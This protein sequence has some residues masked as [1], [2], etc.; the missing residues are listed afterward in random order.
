METNDLNE[1]I[2]VFKEY[3]ELLIPLQS[4]LKSFAETFSGL[5][6]NLEEVSQVFDS[7]I[8]GKLD[9]IYSTLYAQAQKSTDLSS[10]IDVFVKSSDRY[11]DVVSKISSRL[12]SM[13]S[14]I[15]K[16]NELEAKA[17]EQIKK[18]DAVLEE[19]KINYNVKDLQKSLESYNFNVEKVSQFINEDVALKLKEN[20]DVIVQLKAD[21]N[22]L[23]A[24]VESQTNDIK[25]LVEYFRITSDTIKN[26]V[27]AE[28]V[29]EEYIFAILDKWALSRKVKIK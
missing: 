7:D 15:A 12:E 3:R 8:N 13:E 26:T 16:I 27:T 25:S 14:S 19:K 20:N 2:E 18:L 5:K 17:A 4:G 21:N 24:L 23:K 1:L 9:K 22:N 10:R 11:T 28:G 6:L 29:N